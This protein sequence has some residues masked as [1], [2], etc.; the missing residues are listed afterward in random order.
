MK[1]FDRSKQ[2]IIYTITALLI[3]V[4]ILLNLHNEKFSSI[5]SAGDFKVVE[6]AVPILDVTGC[7]TDW[8][9]GFSGVFAV[10]DW[11]FM[12]NYGRYQLLVTADTGSEN[13]QVELYYSDGRSDELLHNMTIHQGSG[14]SI[15]Y[16]NSKADIKYVQVRI[17]FEGEGYLNIKNV[18]I[19][20]D[21][22]YSDTYFFA[23][24]TAIA[25]LM[26]GLYIF[27]LRGKNRLSSVVDT[28]LVDCVVLIGAVVFI[29]Q[30]TFMG[31]M[32][33]AHDMFFH[34]SRI[35][36][37]K[38]A[39]LAGSFPVRMYMSEN[40]GYGY[41]AAMYY[42]DLFMYIPAVLRIIGVSQQLSYTFYLFIVN[43]STAYI[44]YYAARRVF[45]DRFTSLMTSLIYTTAL[46]RLVNI[47]T[48]GAVGEVTAMVFLPLI[49]AG[50]YEIF[51]GD[52]KK[53]YIAA[54]GYTGVI[55]SHILTSLLVFIFS[56]LFGLIFITKIIKER[57]YISLFM[58]F[59]AVL[60]VNLWF[61]GPFIEM[62]TGYPTNFGYQRVTSYRQSTYLSK[63][64]DVFINS[65]GASEGLG[66][67]ITKEMGLSLGLPII[68]SLAALILWFTV[69]K[70]DRKY[71]RTEK[72]AVFLTIFGMLAVWMMTYHFPLYAIVKSSIGELINSIQFP[73][74]L[75]SIA[76]LCFAFSGALG[77]TR[78]GDY[79]KSKRILAVVLA[80]TIAISGGA[81]FY[82]V[83]YT[84]P[85]DP[86]LSEQIFRYKPIVGVL[87]SYREYLPESFIYSREKLNKR[88]DEPQLSNPESV[89]ET[90][91]NSNK[92]LVFSYSGGAG[93]VV[94]P[95]VY[96]PGYTAK[97]SNNERIPVEADSELF[98]KLTLSE[99][100][101]TITVKYTGK[102]H[103]V[104]YDVTSLMFILLVISSQVFTRVKRKKSDDTD[105]L[106]RKSVG[107]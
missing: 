4:V 8:T 96:Y 23:A 73:W 60:A 81:F 36:A 105:C 103:W 5:T 61:I 101:D 85:E 37:I 30:P 82:G 10:S 74:R 47:Y 46:Y 35:D 42:P 98:A 92:G 43:I 13:N 48:R 70:R 21:V 102:A 78:F 104:I 7:M 2:I 27:V 106:K 66:S 77:I 45:K 16:F 59:G 44:C 100:A 58:A 55:Q 80:V 86:N 49:V 33:A 26:L 9:T 1:E 75:L 40:A 89:I 57:R 51:F 14:T 24:V 50:L 39:L 107:D 71:D 34:L 91:S 28:H 29:S 54:I 95:L 87:D 6:Q 12:P 68:F 25:L 18:E 76:T 72:I 11:F 93:E 3:V 79:L 41:G 99:Y 90:F 63:V 65:Y 83:I 94:L 64:L 56:L 84:V 97:N 88:G 38:D 17:V 19:Y 31:Y 69:R 20:S 53:W 62:Y 52:R 32:M 15:S 22:A 67:P